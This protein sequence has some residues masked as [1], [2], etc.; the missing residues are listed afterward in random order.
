M[1]DIHSK[2]VRSRNMAAVKA[3][4][5]KPELLVR[6]ELHKRGFRY[7]LHNKEIEGTHDLYLR[8]YNTAIFINGCFWHGHDCSKGKLPNTN[9]E[10]WDKKISRNKERDLK[11]FRKL[12]EKGITSIQIWECKLNNKTFQMTIDT[13]EQFLKEKHPNE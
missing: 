1:S 10:F 11:N 7:S 13:L 3:K 4:N 6:K 5:T 12:N 8:K 2:E 9:Q